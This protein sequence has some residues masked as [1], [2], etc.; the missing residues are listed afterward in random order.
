MT[1]IEILSV[2]RRVAAAFHA[3]PRDVYGKVWRA[4]TPALPRD[5]AARFSPRRNPSLV[6]TEFARWIARLDGRAVG[7][8]AA[9]APPAPRDVG[10]FGF[11]ESP[12]HPAVAAAL[13]SAAERWLA[14]R[15]RARILGPIAANQ[16][17]EIG[18]LIDGFDRPAA[19]L[20]PYNPP[21][22]ARLLERAGYR[23]AVHLRAY[24]W[25]PD[26][27][28]P[29]GMVALGERLAARGAVRLRTLD[30]GDLESEALLVARL[31]NCA[32]RHMWGYVPVSDAEARNLARQLR[33]VF[34]P[35]LCF[36]AEHAGEPCGA[37]LTVPDAN[38]LIRRIDGRLWPF[39]WLQAL[40]L[41]HRIPR[42]R[43]MALA[44]LPGARSAG[45]AILLMLATHRALGRAGYRY[46][47]LSQ[48][49]DD[50][51]LMRRLLERMGCPVVK[52]YAVFQRNP[53]EGG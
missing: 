45:T 31:L 1:S 51:H 34:D 10:Y 53:K 44:V 47:E 3:V 11:F 19:L 52:R 7:R 28:D 49:F 43:F 14:L 20:T 50:N 29:R 37:A 35:R 5:E 27:A 22:Y 6:G 8:I 33:P 16:R 32:F 48:V 13:L 30:P 2:D 41:R 25:T 24:A 18:L 39:G 17:D 9:F 36:V 12:D 23:P 38:W 26:M 46:A 15:G 4:W 42:A 21:Y 40:R